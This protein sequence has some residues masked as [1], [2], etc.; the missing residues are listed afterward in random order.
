MSHSEQWKATGHRHLTQ[1]QWDWSVCNKTTFKRICPAGHEIRPY[2]LLWEQERAKAEK[3]SG[4]FISSHWELNSLKF[5]LQHWRSH[6]TLNFSSL[7]L[8]ERLEVN[9]MGSRLGGAQFELQF[10]AEWCAN[11]CV[12]VSS[13]SHTEMMSACLSETGR[14]RPGKMFTMRNDIMYMHGKWI[15]LMCVYNPVWQRNVL[16]FILLFQWKTLVFKVLSSVGVQKLFDFQ[17][18]EDSRERDSAMS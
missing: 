16:T 12:R 17:Q 8:G 5:I 10:R 1:E 7:P 14:Y 18:H 3:L 9:Q 2:W 13:R 4:P 11:C 6:H 15:S